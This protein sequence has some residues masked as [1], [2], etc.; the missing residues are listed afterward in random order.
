MKITLILVLSFLPLT[1]FGQHLKCCETEKEVEEYLSGKWKLKDSD[2]KTIY[3][4]WIEKGKLKLESY[5]SDD[6]EK[7]VHRMD[8]DAF[9]EVIKYENGFRL[10]YTHTFETI[11]TELKYLNSVKFITVRDGEER[12]YYKVGK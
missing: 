2:S 8:N 3:K 6:K 1:L 4:Y 7:G 12:E 9:I 11:I 5:K 10:E